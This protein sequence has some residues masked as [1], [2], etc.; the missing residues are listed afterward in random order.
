MKILGI[1][2]IGVGL[3]FVVIALVGVFRFRSVL[4][5]LHAA[6]IGETMAVLFLFLGAMQIRAEG[7][8]IG[9]LVC[10]LVFLWITSPVATHLIASTEWTREDIFRPKEEEEGGS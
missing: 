5:R 7:F 9:K 8:F 2:F 10:M 6:A 4:N 3:A 1:C